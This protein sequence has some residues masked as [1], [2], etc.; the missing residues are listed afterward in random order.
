MGVE[1]SVV[2]PCRNEEKTIGICVD[3]VKKIF[4]EQKIKGEIIVADSSSDKSPDIAKSLALG[5]SLASLSQ[6]VLPAAIKSR[7]EVRKLLSLLIQELRNI[8]FLVGANSV[9]TL[10]DSSLVITG[11]T[12]EWLR[13]RGFN[14]DQYARRRKN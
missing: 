1:V 11:K 4:A 12:A 9:Q 13:I 6:P 8:M 2:L 5:A 10:R 14:I 3:K 7:K